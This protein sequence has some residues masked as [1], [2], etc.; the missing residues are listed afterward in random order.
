[1]YY[2]VLRAIKEFVFVCVMRFSYALVE[3]SSSRLFCSEHGCASRRLCADLVVTDVGQ[4]EERRMGRRRADHGRPSQLGGL[5]GDA[6]S[7]RRP[8][9]GRCAAGQAGP[10][11]HDPIEH[12]PVHR[13]L[14]GRR[15]RAQPARPVRRSRAGRRR[16]RYR[17]HRRAHV[18]RRDIRGTI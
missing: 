7:G 17:I 8:D 18:H 9:T 3:E 1:M 5:A 12:G 13:L 6:G 10:E 16:R 11:E 15:V 14:D 2:Y 4:A